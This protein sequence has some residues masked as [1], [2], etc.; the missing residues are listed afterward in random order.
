MPVGLEEAFVLITVGLEEAFVLITVGLE[1]ICVLITVGLGLL[2]EGF[3]SVVR[4]ARGCICRRGLW[5]WHSKA[6]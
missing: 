2:H 4:G 5:H 3:S 6:L 1:E